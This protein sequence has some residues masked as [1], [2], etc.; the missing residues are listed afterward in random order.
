MTAQRDFEQMPT[1][2]PTTAEAQRLRDFM[3]EM[4]W[5]QRQTSDELQVGRGSLFR[6]LSGE[7]KP[8]KYVWTLC[9]AARQR[10]TQAKAAAAPAPAAVQ[11]KKAPRAKPAGKAAKPAA[12][13]GPRKAAA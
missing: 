8:P 9:D 1:D 6:W 3:A 13:R 7:T 5:T 10:A 4:G 2:K 11:E 12:K